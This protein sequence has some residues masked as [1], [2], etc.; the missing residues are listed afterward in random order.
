MPYIPPPPPLSPDEFKR[1]YDAGART[2]EELDPEFMKWYRERKR[3][4]LIGWACIATSLLI[5]VATLFAVV[6]MHVSE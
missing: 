3:D 5:L 6:Y 2:M 4:S 1:R